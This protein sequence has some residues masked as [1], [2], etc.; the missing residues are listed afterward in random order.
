MIFKELVLQNFGPYAGRH[1]INLNPEINEE[2]HPIILFGGMNGGGKTTLMDAIRLA[3]Y[4]QRAQCSTRNNLGYSEF[5]TQAVNN[6]TSPVEQTRIELS[7]EH[8]IDGQWKE[9]KIVRSWTK[10][11]KDGKDNLGILDTEWPDP[12]LA[13]TWDEYI[14]TLLPLGIS[15]LFL[16][17]G[18]QVK[19]L[20]EQDI[21]PPTVVEA[22]QFL[23]GLEL[24][25]RLSIDLD[26]LASRK[27]KAL[28]SSAQLT[29]IEDIEAKIEKCIQ[30]KKAFENSLN[31]L[32]KQLKNAQKK[33]EEAA[34]KF[35]TEGG[36]IAA[37]RSQ[38]ENKINEFAQATEA[39]RIELRNLA[40][41]NLPLKLITPLLERAKQQGEKELK[42]QQS[43]VAREVIQQRDNR[44]LNYIAKLSL[45]SEQLE[46]IQFFLQQENQE[47]DRELELNKDPWLEV[48]E[49]DTKQLVNLLEHQLPLQLNLAQ[50]Q[51][52]KLKQLEEELDSNERQLAVAAS[53]EAYQKLDETL[54]AAQKELIACK[55]ALE[56]EQ[57]KYDEVS[58]LIEKTKKELAKYSE[59]AIDR[60]NNEHIITSVAK[61]QK[62]LQLFRERLT[63]K[64]L[65]KLEGEVTECF[66]YLLHKSDLVHRVAIDTHNFSL[67][68]YD[69]N[70][71]PV[72][73]HR[74]SAGEKQLLAIAFLWGLAR[75]SGRHLPIAI[76]TPLGRLDSSHRNNLVER[77]FPT[78]SHQVILLSTDTEIGKTE[79]K[80]LREQNAIAREYLLKYDPNKRQTTVTDGYFW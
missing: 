77:Y 66:R 2:S 61:V 48:D 78:A 17:D 73:K 31:N 63:L 46:K 53:P 58:K 28:A 4:G 29:N 10:N 75:V 26:I 42:I 5:L 40:A 80:Q 7:F 16:F 68:L 47:R 51:I 13:N 57:Q 74:L 59:Q 11:P 52:E 60:A 8:I 34:D 70:G 22:I 50:K 38:L 39:R 24:A 21:P 62:T 45:K 1:I 9:L 56:A 41:E 23:L 79:V 30:D 27:R 35:R 71:Q 55:T 44:L 32:Q 18:E 6:Q 43:K 3:L 37:Q 36:K 20:A 49:E 25:E 76:D 14:E 64:K 69:P 12:A 54:K 67:S 65:N 15:N 19:E 72:P 33:H